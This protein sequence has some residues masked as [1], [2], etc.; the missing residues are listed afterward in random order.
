MER[1]CTDTLHLLFYVCPSNAG[2]PFHLCFGLLVQIFDQLGQSVHGLLLVAAV[3]DQRHGRALHDAQAQNAQQALGVDAAF[4]LLDP[5]TA[6]VLI[7]L[8]NKI[9]GRPGV[10]ADLILDCDLPCIHGTALLTLIFYRTPQRASVKTLTLT[11]FYY[12]YLRQDFNG[13]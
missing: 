4:L 7:G 8:L 2:V 10:Q 6:L 12:T 9:S 1:I 5:D 3:G 11:V 13:H